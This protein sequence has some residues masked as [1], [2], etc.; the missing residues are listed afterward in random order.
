MAQAF[1]VPMEAGWRPDDVPIS[2]TSNNPGHYSRSP[3]PAGLTLQLD[4]QQEYGSGFGLPQ[5]RRY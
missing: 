3:L 4:R 5:A 2:E 1:E